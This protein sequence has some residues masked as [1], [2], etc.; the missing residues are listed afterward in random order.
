[1]NEFRQELRD[2]AALEA[3]EVCK[4]DGDQCV[5]LDRMGNTQITVWCIPGP[6]S[7]RLVKRGSIQEEETS[8]TFTIPLQDGFPPAN[9]P[10][11]AAQ[12]LYDGFTWSLTDEGGETWKR[13]PVGACYICT[14]IRHQARRSNG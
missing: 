9:E 7:R 6:E 8:R 1:V 12:I 14:A 4:V 10:S 3:L 2:C 13:D 5:Y 11:V